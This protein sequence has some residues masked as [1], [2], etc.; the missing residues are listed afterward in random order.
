MG[1]PQI[2]QADAIGSAAPVAYCPVHRFYAFDI[3]VDG[4]WLSFDKAMLQLSRAGFPLVAE[5]LVRGSLEDCL[6]LDV[7]RL[8]TSV[9]TRLGYPQGLVSQSRA[10][11][12]WPPPLRVHR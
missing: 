10:P 1:Q 7:N 4:E 6:S 12:G 2:T 9:P 8:H 11:P 3:L 5:P